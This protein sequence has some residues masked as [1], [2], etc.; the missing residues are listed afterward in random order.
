MERQKASQVKKNQNRIRINGF[1]KGK[2]KSNKQ[3]LEIGTGVLKLHNT[4]RILKK[5]GL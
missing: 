2:A 4:I 3:H 5:I 1:R